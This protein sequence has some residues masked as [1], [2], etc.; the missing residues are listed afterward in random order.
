MRLSRFVAH[1]A[2]VTSLLA[3]AACSDDAPTGNGTP[4]ETNQI[5]VRDN[6]FSP[7]SN[8]VNQGSTVTWTWQGSNPHNVTWNESNPPNSATQNSGTYTRTFNVAAGNYSYFCTI[9]ANM[10]GR[11]TVR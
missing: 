11:V 3:A 4:V 1:A 10:T 9:H 7:N 6:F 5:S 8:V 2:V